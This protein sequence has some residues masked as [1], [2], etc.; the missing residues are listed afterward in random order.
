MQKINLEDV[1]QCRFSY[2]FLFPWI[3]WTLS[4]KM[5]NIF[6]I[7]CYIYRYLLTLS[8][9]SE[10]Q[11]KHLNLYDFFMFFVDWH[12]QSMK[13]FLLLFF[14]SASAIM[15]ANEM[16]CWDLFYSFNLWNR[17]NEKSKRK[18][19][20]KMEAKKNF[21]FFMLKNGLSGWAKKKTGEEEENV[22][23]SEDKN[24]FWLGVS[25]YFVR[26]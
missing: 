17:N 24:E 19:H 18:I 26:F 3:F 25:C 13:S 22:T 7:Y 21:L 20:F 1:I 6:I 14:L 16:P 5:V 12:I 10:I 4:F 23:L 8:L 2:L 9:T 15:K 11:S